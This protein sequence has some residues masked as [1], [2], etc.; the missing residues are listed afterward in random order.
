[1]FREILQ[2]VGHDDA[3]L[4]PDRGG[5]DVAVVGIGKTQA[6]DEAFVAGNKAVRDCLIHQGASP[7][8]LRL[9][10]IPTLA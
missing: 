8:Q 1:M 4:A 5:K 3:S 6:V 2:V 7:P 9:G 10:K